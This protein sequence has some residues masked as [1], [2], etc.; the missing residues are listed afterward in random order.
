MKKATEIIETIF[1]E[2][3][4]KK[5]IRK[6]SY[7]AVLCKRDGSEVKAVRFDYYD[8]KTDILL[9]VLPD[10]YPDW[11]CKAIHKLYEEDFD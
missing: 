4:N 7:C 10:L 6:Y 2:N 5:T 3:G 9:H 8:T 1:K 11:K